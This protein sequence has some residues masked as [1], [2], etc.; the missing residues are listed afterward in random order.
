MGNVTLCCV[1]G[2]REMCTLFRTS[3]NTS[4][5]GRVEGSDSDKDSYDQKKS[6]SLETCSA[7]AGAVA[8]GAFF[9]LGAVGSLGGGLGFGVDGGELASGDFGEEVDARRATRETLAG[10][11]RVSFLG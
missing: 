10:V 3:S 11:G 8:S 4:G 7:G 2:C 9:P 5:G 6:C 1:C